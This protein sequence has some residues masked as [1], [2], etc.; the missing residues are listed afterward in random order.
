MSAAF[1]N[2]WPCMSRPRPLTPIWRTQTECQAAHWAS[3]KAECKAA[4]A[5]GKR[6][7]QEEEEPGASSGAGG[8]SSSTPSL[9]TLEQLMALRPRELKGMLAAAGVDATGPGGEGRARGAGAG[10]LLRQGLVRQGGGGGPQHFVVIPEPSVL[11]QQL[12]I[13][14]K[15]VRVLQQAPGGRLRAVLLALS[16]WGGV[17]FAKGWLHKRGVHMIT[18]GACASRPTPVVRGLRATPLRCGRGPRCGQSAAG[19]EG[20]GSRWRAHVGCWM[21]V[22]L[23]ASPCGG[24]SRPRKKASGSAPSKCRLAAG[25]CNGVG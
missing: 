1:A 25:G 20:G 19:V 21:Q 22:C 15:F 24:R 5:R 23:A 9:R 8:A 12:N 14:N 13:N 18:G 17:C 16:A 2:T 11:S 6:Q 7:R 10:A 4:R 3:R